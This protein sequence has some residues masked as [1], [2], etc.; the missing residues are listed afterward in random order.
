LSAQIGVRWSFN[1][2]SKL[3]Q[4]PCGARDLAAQAPECFRKDLLARFAR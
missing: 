3:S 4:N 2:V 1:R